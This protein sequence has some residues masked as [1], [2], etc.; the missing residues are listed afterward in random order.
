M[1]RCYGILSNKLNFWQSRIRTNESCEVQEYFSQSLVVQHFRLAALSHPLR[2][3]WNINGLSWGEGFTTLYQCEVNKTKK[4][5]LEIGINSPEWQAVPWRGMPSVALRWGSLR[6]AVLGAQHSHWLKP[7]VRGSWLHPAGHPVGDERENIRRA[8][9][10][11]YCYCWEEE[12][13]LDFYIFFFSIWE[14][15]ACCLNVFHSFFVLNCVA[16]K[17]QGVQ[18]AYS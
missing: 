11:V 3:Y 8:V 7:R 16:C 1:F 9:S 14:N 13:R 2:I 6:T 4:M 12:G 18:T 5:K 10:S 17:K 15:F